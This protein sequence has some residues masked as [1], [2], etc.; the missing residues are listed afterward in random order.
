LDAG[1]PKRAG[2]PRER[3]RHTD[4]DRLLRLGDERQRQHDSQEQSEDVQHERASYR[5]SFRPGDGSLR[6]PAAPGHAREYGIPRSK[7]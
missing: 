7:P 5:E 4:L 6:A 3:H 1:S 2:R